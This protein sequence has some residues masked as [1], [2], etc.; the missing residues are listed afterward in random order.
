MAELKEIKAE[1]VDID[2]L[3]PDNHN[4]SQFAFVESSTALRSFHPT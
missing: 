2:D 4:F 3:I 1:I